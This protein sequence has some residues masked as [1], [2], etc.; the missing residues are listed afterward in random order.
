M[1]NANLKLRRNRCKY[2]RTF[3][4]ISFY[5][6]IFFTNIKIIYFARVLLYLKLSFVSNAPLFLARVIVTCLKIRT[7]CRTSSFSIDFSEMIMK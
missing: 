2:G 6:A 3:N 4:R 7:S 1:V 5:I